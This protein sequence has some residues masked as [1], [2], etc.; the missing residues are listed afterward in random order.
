VG[1][2]TAFSVCSFLVLTKISTQWDVSTFTI[3]NDFLPSFPLLGLIMEY[4]SEFGREV[5][6]TAVS[7]ALGLSKN[8][9]Y[10][11]T[12]FYLILTALAS[13]LPGY[14]AQFAVA[15]L[16]PFQVLPNGHYL[17]VPLSQP[18]FP[19]GHTL[20]VCAFATVAWFTLGNRKIAALLTI[21][22]AMVSFSRVYVG[23]HFPMDVIGG[24]FLGVAIGSAV[25]VFQTKIDILFSRVDLSW[26]NKFLKGV[27]ER[28]RSKSQYNQTTSIDDE[29]PLWHTFYSEAEF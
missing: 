19:S 14:I 28:V 12:A 3:L 7:I 11:R 9:A 15:R 5:V 16:R 2:S 21:E 8:Q 13:T 22:A 24:V 25:M 6:W 26:N 10:R 18:S 23:A 27:R 1:S 20:V 4:S 29:L 17:L